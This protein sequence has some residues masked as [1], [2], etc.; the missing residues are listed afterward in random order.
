[1]SS[2]S[3]RVA[4][5]KKDT[6]F[7]LL[8]PAIVA[9]RYQELH[10]AFSPLAANFKICYSVKTNPHPR[11]LSTLNDLG[12][13]METVSEREL[14]AVA[15]FS[16]FK[17]FNACAA[18][19]KEM[20]EANAQGAHIILDSPSQLEMMASQEI[21][22]HHAGIRV[23]LFP[24]KFGFSPAEVKPFIQECHSR[25]I[26]ITLLHS[27]P[28]TNVSIQ[29]YERFASRLAGLLPD[30]PQIET[31]DLGG[32]IPGPHGLK[33]RGHSVNEYARILSIHLGQFLSQKTLILEPGRFLVEDAMVLITVVQ[34]LK[35]VDDHSYVFLD[36]GINVLPKITFSPYVFKPLSPSH[37]TKKNVRLAGPLMF[38][39][40]ELGK[41]H[42]SLAPGDR[43]VVENVGA[44][45]T[46]LAWRLSRDAPNIV[47][48]E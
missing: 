42:A 6:P 19:P 11:I 31:I 13:G 34:H 28:G 26:T 1:M 7:F 47:V 46:E 18:T 15:P 41:I 30:L 37:G 20:A 5:E 12:S 43:I 27:H 32:G 16:T 25:G 45:C 39:S 14:Q 8:F 33:Q 36:A 44:Y 48:V 3:W 21:I 22:P 10:T 17:L 2:H 29:D 4:R 23:R 9:A 38:G 24:S 40:D 35:E